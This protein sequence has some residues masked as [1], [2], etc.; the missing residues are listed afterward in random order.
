M[1]AP[2]EH[3]EPFRIEEMVLE[4]SRRHVQEAVFGMPYG[5]R[6]NRLVGQEGAIE[7]PAAGIVLARALAEKLG[8]AP[9]DDIMIEQA[10]GR[11]VVTRIRVSRI[12]EPMVGS[13]AYMELGQL[14]RLVGEPERIN[15][16]HLLLDP[17]HYA[18]FNRRV[19]ETPAL[20]GASYLALAERSMRQGIDRSV[21]TMNF[22]YALFAAV[23]AGGVAFSAARVTLAE[24][25]RDLATLRVVG[26]TRGKCLTS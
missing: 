5:A 11:R 1:T 16:A 21:G 6:L 19:K 15:G 12:V 13:A 24:Q 9:G 7:P 4:H 22:I 10:R 2:S 3:A 23:M 26:F 17:A 18:D 8:A 14:A 20:A 25:E